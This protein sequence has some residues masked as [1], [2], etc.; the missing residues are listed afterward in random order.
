MRR[1]LVAT[2]VVA[3]GLPAAAQNLSITWGEDDNAARTYDP[4]V[5]QSRHETQVICNI[6]DQLIASDGDSSLHPGLA[7]SWSV[8]PDGRSITLKLREDVTFYDG[9]PFNAEAVA[10][11]LDS[12]VDP[13]LGSQGA[14]DVLG[15][16]AGT[17]I[18]GP[19]EVKITYKRPWGA[20][21]PSL[22][23][24]EL[25]MVSPTAV[26]KLG[27]AGAPDPARRDALYAEAQKRIMDAAVWV[28]VHDQ[29]NS[30]AYRAEHSGYRFARTRWNVKFYDVE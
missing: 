18:I 22:S 3:A 6:F 13:K 29:V 10:F 27:A 30:I 20:A 23:Q 11:T 25:S 14:V 15:P 21:A 1:L 4:R 9:T 24:G 2:V 28:P 7:T 17:E 16:Y 8:A 19:Y 12:I 26:K 5:T